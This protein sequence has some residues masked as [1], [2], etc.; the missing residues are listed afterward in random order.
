MQDPFAPLPLC[1][2]LRSCF[3]L[4]V[5]LRVAAQVHMQVFPN[6]PAMCLMV[7][8]VG[9]TEA[10][11]LHAPPVLPTSSQVVF[12]QAH[13]SPDIYGGPVSAPS[14]W[15]PASSVSQSCALLRE[16]GELAQKQHICHERGPWVPATR[17][18]FRSILGWVD[19]E[20]LPSWFRR[21]G[22]N[23]QM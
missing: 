8:A 12:S 15:G 14:R 16:Q 20:A 17:S 3:L 2:S 5:P 21:K 18:Q 7:L 4:T 13:S 22:I 9:P 23:G 1:L 6:F 19:G 10:C 11:P